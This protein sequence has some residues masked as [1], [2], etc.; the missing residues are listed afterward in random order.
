MTGTILS[1]IARTLAPLV[2]AAIA[3]G[4]WA[5]LAQDKA[6]IFV[7]AEN[8]FGRLVVSFPQRLDLPAYKA[9]SENGVLSIEFE[10][11]MAFLLPDVAVTLPDYITIARVDPDK[12]GVRF[13][14]RTNLNFHTLEAGE[15]LFIDLLPVDWQG[16]PPGLPPEVVAELTERAKDAALRAEQQRKA[17]EARTL[18]PVAAL[19]VGRNPTFMRIE[20]D[21]NVETKATFAVAEGAGVL[22]FDWPV[23]LDL[24]AL[25]ADLPTE[26]T[27]VE[28][29]VSLDGSRVTMSLAAGVVPRFYQT[30]PT[31]FIIDVDLSPEEIAALPD[32][33]IGAE[34]PAPVVAATAIQAVPGAPLPAEPVSDTVQTSIAPVVSTIGDTLR[35]AFPFD[36]DTAAAAFRRGDVLWLLFDTSTAVL[37][38]TASLGGVANG[39]MVTPAGDTQIV[40]IDLTADRLATLGVEGRS[41][42][43]SLGNVLLETTEPLP[44]I[45]RRDDAGR[46]QLVAAMAR[47][48]SVHAFRDPVAGDVLTVVTAFGPP[49]GIGRTQAFVDLTALASAHGLV[50]KPGHDD[51]GVALDGGSAVISAAAGL[52][53]SDQGQSRAVVA[54]AAPMQRNGFLDLAAQTAP[55][56]LEFAHEREA[57]IT[58]AAEAEGSDRDAARLKYAQFLVA[59]QFAYEAIGVLQIMESE[60]SSDELRRS[61]RLTTAVANILAY[62]P[63]DAL[64]ILSLPSYAEEPD[65]LLW[66]TIARSE[67][68]Q[69][70]RA[71]LDGMVAESVLDAYPRWVRQKFLFAAIRAAAETNDFVLARRYLDML[72][73]KNLE[74]DEVAWYQLFAGRI[75]EAEGRR[76]EAIDAYGQVIAADIRPSR[77]EAVY[78]TVLL[79]DRSGEIDL[80]KASETLQSEAM[81]WR[82]NWLEADMQRLLADLFFRHKDYRL[83]FETV[84]QTVL[85]Y[86]DRS[87]SDAMLRQA[88]QA[89]ESLYLNGEGDSLQPVDA[90]GLYYDFRQLTPPGARGDE[91]IRNL[92]RRLVKV[93]LLKQAA[94]LLEYQIDDR[95]KGVAQAQVAAEL[96]VIRIADRDPESALRVLNRTR[97]PDLSPQLERQRRILEARALIDAGRQDLALDLLRSVDGR[98]A[99]LLRID[100]LWKSKQYVAAGE[101]IEIIYSDDTAA[102]L[103]EPARVNI[104]KAA[105]GMVLGNDRLGLQRIRSKFAERMAQTPEWP[106]FDFVTG[107][108]ESQS[109]EF[110]DVAREVSGMDSLDAFLAAYR[111]LYVGA[112]D[113]APEKASPPNDAL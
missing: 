65:A 102:L 74:P 107:Q 109:V 38:P 90:L 57:M 82:G 97:L 12:K 9:R 87:S 5:A 13:G 51:V 25:K 81:V 41:W 56:P 49:R 95:L 69:Y 2:L 80:Q 98:D 46:F 33:I 79:L 40:R 68:G 99:D 83:G 113:P 96:A 64:T 84:R 111:G 85:S 75:A 72:E 88:Q 48:G 104:V 45:R 86:P 108:I 62:R 43:L 76:D 67:A 1:H 70:E 93:D 91:M 35:I 73:F 110:R 18:K 66:R 103:S 44:L 10:E 47:P 89:F 78:R 61:S 14:L 52:V 22:D 58:T 29:S 15:K 23:P 42:V 7:T 17:V 101:L 63:E 32:R 100:G 105:V 106:I 24:Y 3:L 31:Q 6:Q 36:R 39:F 54:G 77:A 50:L 94:D 21:W 20:F 28:N 71:R 4:P 8:G 16:L 37:T 53:L 19:R 11:P 55:D 59:N 27:S 60:L 112:D 30:S 26:I 92:A 34:T